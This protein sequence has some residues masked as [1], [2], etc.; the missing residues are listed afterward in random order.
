MKSIFSASLVSA[1]ALGI[2]ALVAPSASM[3]GSNPVT[4]TPDSSNSAPSLPPSKVVRNTGGV[5]T[6]QLQIRVTLPTTTNTFTTDFQNQL[7]TILNIPSDRFVI[8][9]LQPG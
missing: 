5:Q 9:S 2:A 7:S 4:K 6:I 1:L 8:T 3:A